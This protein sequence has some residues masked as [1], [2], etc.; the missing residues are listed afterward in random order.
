[1]VLIS[2]E[3]GEISWEHGEI[4]NLAAWI[5]KND[6]APKWS[7]SRFDIVWVFDLDTA[8]GTYTCNQVPHLLLAGD[9]PGDQPAP[10]FAS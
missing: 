2:W 3:H 10:I 9:Q 6:S 1:M 5:L 7:G 4:P 8:S